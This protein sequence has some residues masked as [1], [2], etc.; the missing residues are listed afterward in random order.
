M[1]TGESFEYAR[2]GDCGCA[3]LLDVPE[4]LADCYAGLYATGR[5]SGLKQRLRSLAARACGNGVLGQFVGAILPFA[6]SGVM[7]ALAAEGIPRHA[8]VLDVGSGAG[9]LLLSLRSLGFDGNLVGIDPFLNEASSAVTDVDL[10]RSRI[11]DV[12][13]QYDLITLVHTLEHIV[14]QSDILAA[15]RKRLAPG[16]RCIVSIPLIGGAV[17]RSEGVDWIQLDP[18]RHVLLHTPRSLG[19]LAA[20]QGLEIRRTLW[21]ST[22]FQFWGTAMTRH[23]RALLPIERAYARSLWRM[24]TDALRAMRLNRRGDGDQATF[25]L[26]PVDEGVG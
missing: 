7:R 19:L 11:E 20:S 22:S 12:Q 1:G 25:V 4:L 16:G 9:R 13:G 5:P 8:S 3:W 17:W 23:N 21:D 24:P 15:V 18:P 14:D 26:S 6:H 2:C 10:R